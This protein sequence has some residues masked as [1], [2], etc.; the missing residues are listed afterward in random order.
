MVGLCGSAGQRLSIGGGRDGGG[1]DDR[2][3][4]NGGG[5][6]CGRFC[7][8]G[9]ESED[10]GLMSGG[11]REWDCI[12]VGALGDVPCC[13]GE[14]ALGMGSVSQRSSSSSS[15]QV[16]PCASMWV[17]SGWPFISVLWVSSR[18]GGD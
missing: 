14:S 13:G 3:W 18:L 9:A 4:E 6:S 11:W 2:E 7:G 10:G 5:C 17:T 15:S 16:C 8:L 1:G 12:R